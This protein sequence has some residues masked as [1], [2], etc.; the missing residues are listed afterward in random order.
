[1][2]ERLTPLNVRPAKRIVSIMAT[3]AAYAGATF[4]LLVTLGCTA[5][6]VWSVVEGLPVLMPVALGA[7]ALISGGVVVGNDW[8]R[9]WKPLFSGDK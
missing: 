2:K 4:S 3:G 7:I 9:I 1:M 5:G 8:P 6:A